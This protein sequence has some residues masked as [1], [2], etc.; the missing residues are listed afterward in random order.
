MKIKKGKQFFTISEAAQYCGM[1][2]AAVHKA[3]QKKRLKASWGSIMVE[4]EGWRISAK[5]M[6]GFLVLPEGSGKSMI[7]VKRRRNRGRE[8]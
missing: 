2:R 4:I 6:K 5:D 1:T 3:I 8:E 7:A